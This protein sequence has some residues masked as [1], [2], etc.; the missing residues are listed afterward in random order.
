MAETQLGTVGVVWGIPSG[1]T[2]TG[3][4]TSFQPQSLNLSREADT[5]EVRNARGQTVTRV[6]YNKRRSISIEVVVTGTSIAAAKTNNVA[7]APGTIVTIA[8]TATPDDDSQIAELHSG[9]YVCERASK[10]MS[11]TSE[12]RLSMDLTQ[13][14]END[15]AVAVAAS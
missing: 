4:L 10:S 13:H 15:L 14:E 7:P 11:T 1:L 8:D 6:F 5:A 3:V 12:V 2:M 9:K